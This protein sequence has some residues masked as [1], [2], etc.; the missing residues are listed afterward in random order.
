MANGIV[1]F[2]RKE[3]EVAPEVGDDAKGDV[4]V[5]FGESIFQKRVRIPDFCRFLKTLF[6]TRSPF[7]LSEKPSSATP[8][9]VQLSA[10][11]ELPRDHL[12][13]PSLAKT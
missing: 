11:D 9:G 13:S 8:D 1:D 4:V 5:A 10:A 12:N 2:G 6:L 3:G 7:I